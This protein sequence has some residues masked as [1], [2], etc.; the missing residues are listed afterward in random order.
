MRKL[1]SAIEQGLCSIYF[2]AFVTVSGT[3]FLTTYLTTYQVQYNN[4]H[5]WNKKIVD[6]QDKIKNLPANTP[7]KERINF[8]KD[9]LAFEKDS[10]NMKNAIYSSL[11]QFFG[12]S[13]FVITL[14]LAWLNYRATQEK[15]VTERYSTSIEQLGNEKLEV[16][17]GGIYALERISKDSNKDFWTVMEVLSAFIREEEFRLQNNSSSQYNSVFST[18]SVTSDVQ[19]ALTVIKRRNVSRDA[20]NQEIDLRGSQLRKVNLDKARFNGACLAKVNFIEANLKEAHLYNANLSET[21]LCK[22]DLTKANLIKANLYRAILTQANL[23]NANLKKANLEQ[24][25]LREANFEEAIF[26]GV[27]LTGADLKGAN[28][29]NAIGLTQEQINQ[30][31]TDKTTILPTYLQLSLSDQSKPSIS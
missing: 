17:I 13:F 15:Q 4:V 25:N 28:L 29:S 21:N 30:A 3:I 27:K 20:N 5:S 19:A 12:G 14:I 26:T 18:R 23:K 2:A 31:S 10:I 16:R 7:S 1:K 8:E 22:A 24:A 9:G 6:W 11:L